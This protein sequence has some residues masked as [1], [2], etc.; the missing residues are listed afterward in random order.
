MRS[1]LDHN[2]LYSP[3]MFNAKHGHIRQTMTGAYVIAADGPTMLFFDPGLVTRDV[4]LPPIT[5]D[6]GQLLIISNL[7][8]VAALNILDAGGIPQVQIDP[9]K[10]GIFASW[11][12]GW[13]SVTA[14]HFAP[15][16]PVA[17][18]PVQRNVTASP[19]GVGASDDILNITIATGTPTCLLPDAATRAGKSITFKDVAGNF[20]AHPLGISAAAG[21]Q[22]DGLSNVVLSTNYQCFV[23]RPYND[24]ANVGW[25]IE[26]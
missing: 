20:G 10:M 13:T 12:Q 24:G 7:S 11:A 18:P 6:A 2:I 5:P 26:Q 3:R 25:A 17:A 14:A 16:P 21:Q 15:T 22:M 9:T 19:V 1:N 8:A 4:F 23:L